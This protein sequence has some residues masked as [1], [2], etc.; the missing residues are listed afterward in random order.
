MLLPLLLLLTGIGFI[1]MVSLR[2]PLRDTKQWQGF[3][4]GIMAGVVLLAIIATTDVIAVARNFYAMPLAMAGLLFLLLVVFGTGPGGTGVKVNLFGA[5][6]IEVIK[7]LIAFFAAGYLAREW[8]K[9]RHLTGREFGW[10]TLPRRREILPL[11]VCF[12]VAL[13]FLFLSGELGPA[14]VLT[15]TFLAIY[16]LTRRTATPGV[17][18]LGVLITTVWVG[19]TLRFPST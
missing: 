10:L 19:Y 7:V 14:L 4:L 11:L 3:A 1:Y 8:Q 16:C 15:L 2:D 17:A 5:Q 13:A 9:L 12:A 6:P 18:L